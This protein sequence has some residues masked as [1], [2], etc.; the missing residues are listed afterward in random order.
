M[1]ATEGGVT[2]W[3]LLT[4]AMG[5]Q[6]FDK[7]FKPQFADPGSAGYKALQ[8]ELDAV[9]NGWVSPGSVTLDDGPSLDKF[10][11]GAG[12]ILFASSPGNLPTSNDPKQSSIAPHAKGGADPGRE[13]PGRDRSASRRGSRSRSPRSTRTRR[14]PSSSSGWS[15]SNQKLLYK[16]AGMLPCRSSVVS[17]MAAKGEIAGRQRRQRAVHARAAAV[18]AGRAELVLGVLLRRAG[19]D[20]LRVKGNTSVR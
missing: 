15:R 6:L 13:R 12:A 14:G 17:D 1:A 10:N 3:Y 19:P 20:E 11:A 5:G 9:K 2:P 8:W 4:L 7:D 16:Q 18:P